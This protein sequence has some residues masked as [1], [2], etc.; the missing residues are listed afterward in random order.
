MKS[1]G[2]FF[3][4]SLLLS[5]STI[6]LPQDY[7]TPYFLLHSG[8]VWNYYNSASPETRVFRIVD[9]LSIDDSIW[10]GYA[11]PGS[12]SASY[13]LRNSNGKIFALNPED[14]TKYILFDFES[15]PQQFWNIPPVADNRNQC[16]WGAVITFDGWEDSVRTTN[17]TFYNC[18]RFV[19]SQHPCSD[20]GIIETLFSRDFGLVAFTE[21]SI[22]GPVEWKLVT[23][24]PDTVEITGTYDY[25]GNP[26]LSNPCPPGIVSAL[27][28]VNKIL[29]LAYHDL[30]FWDD[31]VWNNYQ[32]QMGD[33]VTAKGI[34]TQRTDCFGGNYEQLELIDFTKFTDTGIDNE[35][36]VPA[37]KFTQVSIYPNPFNITTTINIQ[38]SPGSFPANGSNFIDVRIFDI[39][40][41]EVSN[42]YSGNIESNELEFAWNAINMAS[43]CYFIRILIDTKMEIYKLLLQK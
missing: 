15:G 27:H 32:P 17:R 3:V 26:C 12:D 35:K 11:L 10:F 30:W 2:L 40:G 24:I 14:S 39:L 25:A 31:I 33:S 19:H 7:V 5:A 9:E 16:Q 6:I 1:R 41:S 43:G 23:D 36:F 13:Y 28:I 34:I 21:N 42:I 29:I 8:Y 37:G 4:I 20:F 38:L 18:P 22:V